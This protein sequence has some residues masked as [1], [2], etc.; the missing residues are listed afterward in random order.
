MKMMVERMKELGKESE[1]KSWA[2]EQGILGISDRAKA[3]YMIIFNMSDSWRSSRPLTPKGA[4]GLSELIDLGYV[5]VDPSGTY[6]KVRVLEEDMDFV[7][8]HGWG[9]FE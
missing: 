4:E 2:S 9:M 3:L 5:M 8:E 7:V 1:F 6:R